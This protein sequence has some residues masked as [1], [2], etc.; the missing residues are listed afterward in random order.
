MFHYKRLT[1]N[2][3][4]DFSKSWNKKD[5]EDVKG[6]IEGLEENFVHSFSTA[7]WYVFQMILLH[8]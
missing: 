4:N 2:M 6:V 1:T 7:N 3:H 5:N 8:L